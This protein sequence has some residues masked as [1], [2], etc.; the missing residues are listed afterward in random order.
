ME[1]RFGRRRSRNESIEAVRTMVEQGATTIDTAPVYGF[2]I[3]TL[4]DLGYGNAE[5][6]V[7]EAVKGMRDKVQIITKCGLNYDR[8]IGPQSLY[9][10]MTRKEI[11]EGCEGSLKRLQVDYIDVLF[12]H[13][14][15]MKTPLE[16]MTDAL[17]D[18]RRQERFATTGYQISRR[19]IRLLH[20]NCCLSSA[21][22]PAILNGEP[23]QRRSPQTASSR[24]IGTMTYG[25]LGS[26]ILP[27]R[28]DSRVAN[29]AQMMRV[30]FY[31]L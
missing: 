1:G 8:S 29:F 14:P 11:V 7:G 16:E 5:V 18:L 20:M 26:G 6:L 4:P 22:Q 15:D 2:G 12:V 17:S 27:T 31:N 24:G 10:S 23:F 21:V 19:R 30:S 3:P 28:G 9:K 13:W 25:S